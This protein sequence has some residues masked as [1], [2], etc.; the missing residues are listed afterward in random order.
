MIVAEAPGGVPDIAARLICERLS[1]ALGQPMRVENRAGDDGVQAAAR[2]APAGSTWI[3]APASVLV[4]SPYI[5]DLV[6]Y[7]PED[8]F[9]GVAMVGATPFVVV[10]N[11][12]LN[13]KS[14]SDL[15]ALVHEA[16]GR[17]CL[18]YTSPSPRD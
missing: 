18:L 6:P 1:R 14:L 16:P 15:I 13:V 11:P 2:A 3:F 4:I 7:S 17:L 12:E 9:A 5:T 10:A 8:D